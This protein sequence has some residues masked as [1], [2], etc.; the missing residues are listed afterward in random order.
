MAP[1]APAWQMNMHKN[2]NN[3]VCCNSPNMKRFIDLG[4][5]PLANNLINQEGDE[6]SEF[7]LEVKYCDVCWHSQLSIAVDPK[8]LFQNYY[9]VTGT[10][11]TMN[12]YCE[13]LA[14]KI[15][16]IFGRK[17][18]I[19][20]IA[21][22]DG[23]LLE[24]FSKF[25]WD[26]TGV[27]PA[28]NIAPMARAK[29]IEVYN[30]FFASEKIEFGKKFE[31]ITALN[32]FAH[33]PNPLEFMR[34]C[35]R[36][37]SKNGIIVIQT[38]QRDMVE[39]R[40]FDT[41]YHE[42]ISFFSAKSMQKLCDRAGLKLY[43]ID[44]PSIHGG[45]YVFYIS[46]NRQVQQ[47]VTQRIDKEQEKGRFDKEIY[48]QFQSDILQIKKNARQV[49]E[50]KRIIG[51]GAAAK[52]IVFLNFINAKIECVIDENPLKQG[53][54]IPKLNIPIKS[55]ES[56]PTSGDYEVAVLAWNFYDEIIL[57]INQKD[58]N[59]I[60]FFPETQQTIEDIR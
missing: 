26:L 2:I 53:K 39:D 23:T 22:N 50:G 33:V 20:D 28:Q 38:S 4:E 44:T 6:Y 56:L 3:C 40:Q 51:F 16:N 11:R 43:R 41:I 34:E 19:L 10:S 52:G 5:Q 7:P 55:L 25:D 12:E 24:K 31:V 9:Y 13:S 46:E 14:K 58:R 29:G 17:A 1:Y 57:R 45:S 59:I 15:Y 60:K 42:H 30:K 37:L 35:K 8:T 36:N 27:E 48:T 49:L 18:N 21:C 47:S 54:I 32:V